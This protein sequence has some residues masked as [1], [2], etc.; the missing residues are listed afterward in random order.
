MKQRDRG[1]GKGDL[2]KMTW[3]RLLG[4]D[5]LGYPVRDASAQFSINRYQRVCKRSWDIA[6]GKMQ[7]R[8]AARD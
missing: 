7:A 5:D 3:E 6:K 2:G 4:K 8:K 1:S